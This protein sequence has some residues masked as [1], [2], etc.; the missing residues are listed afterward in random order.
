[1]TS[2]LKWVYLTISVT[3][4]IRKYRSEWVW[5]YLSQSTNYNAVLNAFTEKC[6]AVHFRSFQTLIIVNTFL[7]SQLYSFL[8]HFP[9]F[10]FSTQGINI[11]K[12]V[13]FLPQNVVLP[14]RQS[15]FPLLVFPP[16]DWLL[17][18]SIWI[19]LASTLPYRCMLYIPASWKTHNLL[20][21]LY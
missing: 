7:Q 20:L 18:P 3:R 4:S 14:N 15:E 10:S 12:K 19:L 2:P 9:Y 8:C 6:S 16:T 11:V 5:G 17:L 13:F 21:V 1:M